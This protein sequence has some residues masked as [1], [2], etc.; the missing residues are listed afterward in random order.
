MQNSLIQIDFQLPPDCGSAD[1]NVYKDLETR[2]EDLSNGFVR[3]AQEQSKIE[4]LTES[5]KNKVLPRNLIR[6]S[7]DVSRLIFIYHT[8]PLKELPPLK[9]EDL[10]ALLKATSQRKR[11]PSSSLIRQ[12]TQLHLMRFDLLDCHK[13]LSN[14]LLAGITEL[15]KKKQPSTLK[16]KHKFKEILFNPAGPHRF[17]E[18][19]KGN[20]V[21]L[22]EL[23]QK[24]SI[25]D[26]EDCRY[27][28]KCKRIYYIET[29]KNLP[30]GGEDAILEE[31][32]IVKDSPYEGGKTLAHVATSILIARCLEESQESISE[33]WRDCVMG[34]L[35]DPRIPKGSPRFQKGWGRIDRK[36]TDAM[37]KWLSGLDL[38]LFLKLIKEHASIEGNDD[39][40]R[41]FEG[42]K[43]FLEGLYE[44]SLID[45]SRL[46]LPNRVQRFLKQNYNEEQM[47]A[48]TNLQGSGDQSL[49]YLQVGST[50]LTSSRTAHIIEGTHSFALRIFMENPVGDFETRHSVELSNFFYKNHL[51]K[52]THNPSSSW[53]SS[54]QRKLIDALKAS[55]FQIEIDS[56][57]VLSEE[58]YRRY[59]QHSPF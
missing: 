6:E 58:N 52:I 26:Q 40:L 53:Q 51:P 18:K 36:Y 15:F 10:E 9:D 28:Q 30:L 14:Y 20:A 3:N 35:G 46:L 48:F 42:R 7:R 4:A 50:S 57:A 43:I 29:L 41:M 37:V 24:L 49:I 22:N 47:P 1:E 38:K 12:L 17:V 39:L 19:A 34:L 25:P 13:T 8:E 11:G 23:A 5:L 33:P 54:W 59:R 55:P 21:N 44:Q 56:Q 45:Y 16:Y 31:L 32:Q 27:F 2:L